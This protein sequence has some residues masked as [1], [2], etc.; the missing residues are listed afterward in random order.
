[1][2]LEIYGFD[3]GTEEYFKDLRVIKR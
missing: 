2:W 3:I 1:M